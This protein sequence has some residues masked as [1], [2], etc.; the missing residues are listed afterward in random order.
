MYVCTLAGTY[1]RWA[2]CDLSRMP[3]NIEICLERMYVRGIL[4]FEPRNHAQ[5]QFMAVN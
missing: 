2:P 3:G 5:C 4:N 1:F